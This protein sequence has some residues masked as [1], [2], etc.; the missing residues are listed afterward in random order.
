MW[1]QW[2]VV[3]EVGGVNYMDAVGE[4]CGKS[5]WVSVGEVGG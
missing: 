1:V 4:V 5:M 3:D 2:V